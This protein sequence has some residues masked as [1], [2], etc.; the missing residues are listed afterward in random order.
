MI[1]E[2]RSQCSGEPIFRN[3]KCGWIYREVKRIHTCRMNTNGSLVSSR[4]A[5]IH[6]VI[7]SGTLEDLEQN[8]VTKNTRIFG[9][10]FVD[11][12][13]HIGTVFCFKIILIAQNCGDDRADTIATKAPPAQRFT[14]KRFFSLTASLRGMSL[15][16]MDGM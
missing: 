5:E 6:G 8:E 11:Q 7:V 9:S 16:C 10:R 12:V 4:S 15:H 2:K 3:R 1:Q 14:Q 13:K